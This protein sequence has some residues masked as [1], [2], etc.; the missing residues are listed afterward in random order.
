MTFA[1]DGELLVWAQGTRSALEAELGRL[2][3]RRAITEAE[4]EARAVAYNRLIDRIRRLRDLAG[5]LK[6]KERAS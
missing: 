5:T 1:D 6:P 2:E 3:W 4:L